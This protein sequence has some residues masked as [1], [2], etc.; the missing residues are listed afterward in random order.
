MILL[1]INKN[2]SYEFAGFC[3]YCGKMLIHKPLEKYREGMSLHC[4]FCIRKLNYKLIMFVLK[5][6]SRLKAKEELK[7]IENDIY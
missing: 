1:K 2:N 6:K 7:E 5:D 3:D 4:Y